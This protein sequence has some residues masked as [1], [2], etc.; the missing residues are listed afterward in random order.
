MKRFLLALPVMLAACG[1]KELPELTPAQ[2]RAQLDP[3]VTGSVLPQECL[4]GALVSLEDEFV[5]PEREVSP[6]ARQRLEALAGAGLLR[7]E[8]VTDGGASYLRSTLT[9][10]AFNLF[11]QPLDS[12]QDFTRACFSRVSLLGPVKVEPYK[13]RA[14]V[15]QLTYQVWPVTW[16]DALRAGAMSDYLPAS[17]GMPRQVVTAAVWDDGA[18]QWKVSKTGLAEQPPVTPA[19]PN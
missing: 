5:R 14:D 15:R 8:P 9:L 17:Y 12:R 4:T 13:D 2:A 3:L 18:G 19:T 1:G 16:P 11:Y 10:D 7:L 6:E